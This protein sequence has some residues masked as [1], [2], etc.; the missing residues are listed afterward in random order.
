M[1]K[2]RFVLERQSSK[3]GKMKKGTSFFTWWDAKG[4]GDTSGLFEGIP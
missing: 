1:Q 3:S 4:K 2:C